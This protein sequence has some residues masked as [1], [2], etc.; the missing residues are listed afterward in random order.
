MNSRAMY[1][2]AILLLLLF[3]I[4]IPAF[5]AS[6]PNKVFIDNFA[7]YYRVAEG[8]VPK[9]LELGKRAFDGGLTK[10]SVKC[11]REVLVLDPDNKEANR[12]LGRLLVD[13]Q[14]MKPKDRDERSKRANSK[15]E[16]W[17]S[18]W[19]TPVLLTEL[20]K[21]MEAEKGLKIQFMHDDLDGFTLFHMGTPEQVW[22]DRRLVEST[23]HAWS[24]EFGK[25]VGMPKKKK[26]S[27]IIKIGR[28][29]V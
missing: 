4:P 23:F 6:T 26:L 21:S 15:A 10:Q 25:T 8:K 18:N 2:P 12:Y 24:I 11:F 7:A 28:A 19:V 9:L 5:G 13:K 3:A 1:T 22:S 14:W 16:L 17:G 27:V 29:H 20:R